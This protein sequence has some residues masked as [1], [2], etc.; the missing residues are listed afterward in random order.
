ML[1]KCVLVKYTAYHDT[2]KEFFKVVIEYTVLRTGL[3][4]TVTGGLV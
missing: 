4:S 1:Y 3:E 2:L